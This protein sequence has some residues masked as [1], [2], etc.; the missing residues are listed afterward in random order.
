MW[1]IELTDAAGRRIDEIIVPG[2]IDTVRD[3][4]RRAVD[5][6]PEAAR[7]RLVSTDGLL[8]YAY[9]EGAAD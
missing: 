1:G 6:R 9:P 2:S 7:A 4:C 5:G 3:W 8:E